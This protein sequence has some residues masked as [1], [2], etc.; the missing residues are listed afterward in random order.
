M[1]LHQG[2]DLDDMKRLSNALEAQ[3][4]LDGSRPFVHFGHRFFAADN[5]MTKAKMGLI[6][7]EAPEFDLA[8]I[9]IFARFLNAVY[10]A[11]RLNNMGLTVSGYSCLREAQEGFDLLRLV[12]ADNAVGKAVLEDE[13]MTSSE[14]VEKLVPFENDTPT[15]ALRRNRIM[16]AS[17]PSHMRTPAIHFELLDDGFE[18]NVAV[19]GRRIEGA[20]SEFDQ[21]ALSLFED[22]IF[23]FSGE[24]YS[25]LEK[26]RK[27]MMVSIYSGVSIFNKRD[28]S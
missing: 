17:A 11:M 15:Y 28:K 12:K 2:I 8:K 3:S 16:K 1:E 25:D 5:V 22:C 24:L 6:I 9:S 20:Q 4:E 27:Q 13:P 21:I 14:I 7:S 23:E 18:A 26:V 10:A 19:G